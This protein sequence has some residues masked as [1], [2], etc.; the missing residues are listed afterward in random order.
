[1]SKHDHSRPDE[2]EPIVTRGGVSDGRIETGEPITGK[3]GPEAQ[4]EGTEFY[5]DLAAIALGEDTD[6]FQKADLDPDAD[7]VR[8][9]DEVE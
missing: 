5:Q 1:M 9:D 6:D 7:T 8:R 2:P 4:E 3:G